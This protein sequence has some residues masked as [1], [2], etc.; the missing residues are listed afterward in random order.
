[1]TTR[2]A[3]SAVRTT[4]HDYLTAVQTDVL[5]SDEVEW[6]DWLRMRAVEQARDA[7]ADYPAVKAAI[8]EAIVEVAA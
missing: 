5:D 3:L 8:V 6:L 4:T 7:G 1:M 2:E